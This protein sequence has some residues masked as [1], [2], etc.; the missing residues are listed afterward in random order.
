MGKA[1]AFQF[2]TGDWMKDAQ[3]GKC[4]PAT[5]GIWIDAMC[6]MHDSDRSGTLAGTPDQ[7]IRVL[8]CS[9]AELRAAIAELKATG[10]ADVTERNGSVTLVNRRMQRDYRERLMTRERVKRHRCNGVG[11]A[12]V[13]PSSST[14][15]STSVVSTK[16]EALKARIK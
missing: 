5:R 6:A 10:A 16:R 4:S 11:N 9:L 15:S 7:L 2:Y 3:L 8:R 13:S 1:P 14:S 12:D